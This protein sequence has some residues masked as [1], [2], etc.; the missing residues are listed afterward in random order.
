MTLKKE[1]EITVAVVEDHA[2][3][4]QSL[5]KIL[6]GSEGIRCTAVCNSGEQ[7]LEILPSI[8]PRVVLM[9]IS[10]PGMDGVECVR[11]L[12]EQMPDASILM[13]TVHDQDEPIFNSL[14]AGACG[15]LHKPLRADEL[16][17]AIREVNAGGSPMTSNIARRVVRAF[18]KP[19]PAKPPGAA[20]DAE[21]TERERTVLEFMAQ[22]YLYKEIADEMGVSWHTVHT[23]IRHIYEKLHVRSRTE[24]VAK[25][26]TR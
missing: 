25:F 8:R 17:A 12:V 13:L 5:R 1:A 6:D 15:Y 2:P 18:A 20:K 23:H 7:A 24:A 21:L 4:R 16:V 10:L 3:V 19:G 9:D 14:E 11:R 22:G 26:L